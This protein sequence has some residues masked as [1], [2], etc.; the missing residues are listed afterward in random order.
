[1]KALRSGPVT[2]HAPASSANLGP[3]F[4]CAGLALDLWDTYTAE[5]TDERGVRVLTSGE[6]AGEVPHDCSHAVAVA[7][8]HGFDALGVRPAGFTLTCVNRIPHARG[9]GSSAAAIIG[10]LVLARALV[11]DGA[12]LDDQQLLGVA[13]DLESHP[14]N[15]AAAIAGGFSVGWLGDPPGFIQLPVSPRL[16]VTLCIP[17]QP[18]MTR[19]ARTVLSAEVARSDA[20]HNIARAALLPHALND[21]PQLLMVATEDALHQHERSAMY[22]EST[23]LMGALRD[24]GI[25]AVIS[26]AGPAVLA[27]AEESNVAPLADGWTVRG[28]SVPTHGA[29]VEA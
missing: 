14:D 4:D 11:A 25:P 8:K 9:L 27:F 16:S 10:G 20:V 5:I 13:L 29:W 22:P 26:G 1:M 6:G 28:S 18:L 17:S 15:L 19:E 23:A 21:E 2:V 24:S 12:R 7:M 3:A